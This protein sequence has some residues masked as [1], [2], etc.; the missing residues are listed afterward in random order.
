MVK[1]PD[2]DDEA[3]E[4]LEEWGF[5][6]YDYAKFLNPEKTKIMAYKR[7]GRGFMKDVI[8]SSNKDD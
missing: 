2:H 6:I 3:L 4:V 8:E 7:W 5:Y 1:I